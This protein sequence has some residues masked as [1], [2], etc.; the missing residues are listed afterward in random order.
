MLK[1]ARMAAYKT[2][3]RPNGWNGDTLPEGHFLTKKTVQQVLIALP[4]S[5]GLEVLC[6]K[7]WVVNMGARDEKLM[8]SSL[9]W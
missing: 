7:V 6:G 8:N 2:L 9:L 1:E 4:H 3:S 5:R